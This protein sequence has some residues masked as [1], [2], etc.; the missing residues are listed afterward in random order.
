MCVLS[1][2]TH[3]LHTTPF[4]LPVAKTSSES[5]LVEFTKS[6]MQ[7]GDDEETLE[8]MTYHA[9]MNLRGQRPT[10]AVVR[11]KG[12]G[13][14]HP[15]RDGPVFENAH[16]IH[17]DRCDKNFVYY[18]VNHITFPKAINVY[19]NSHPCDSAVLWSWK[20]G[21]TTIWLANRFADYK[22]RWADKRD[23][24]KVLPPEEAEPTY[25]PMA[26]ASE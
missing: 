15:F 10:H 21:E 18:W 6:E 16:T 22:T 13:D 4:S 23:C 14:I 9:W 8:I 24:V 12:L 19:L 7:G 26:Q 11:V 25:A 2:N 17:I 1:P 20:D 5:F 3:L